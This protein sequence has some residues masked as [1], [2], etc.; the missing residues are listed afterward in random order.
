[1]LLYFTNISIIDT[2]PS[3]LTHTVSYG[4]IE[5][6]EVIYIPVLAINEDTALSLGLCD[7]SDFIRHFM[8]CMVTTYVFMHVHH[9]FTSN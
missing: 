4:T 8:T 2:Q 1:M 5:M 6:H 7:A 3:N 9:C